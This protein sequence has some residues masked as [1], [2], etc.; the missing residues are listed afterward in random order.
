[1]KIFRF[2]RQF[3]ALLLC[4]TMILGLMPGTA[5]A[6]E[7]TT[8]DEGLSLSG[9]SGSSEVI[10]LRE[11]NI[12][13]FDMGNGTF[14]AI[15][16]S[17][18]VH[19]L[20]SDG[21]W[22]D[23]DFGMTLT[24][25]RS[26][27]VYAN[28]EAGAAF[29][30]NYVANQPIM[31]L[32]D[33]ENAISMSLISTNVNS[34]ARLNTNT[35][36]AAEVT[37]PQNSFQ[38]I[39]DAKSAD[40]S[41]KILYEEVLPGVDLEYIVDPGT[42]K[43]NIIVNEKATAYQYSFAL[44]L[45]GL[46]PVM[47][48]DGSIIVYDQDADTKEYEIPA[49]FMYDALGNVSE[50]VA[51]ALIGSGNT[52]TLTV[53]A[54]ADWINTEGRSFPVTIDP[55][56]VISTE[57]TYDT[58]IDSDN[59]DTARGSN[60]MLWVRSNRISYIKVPTPSIPSY[61][62]VDWA[63][64]TAFYY[65]F[66]YVTSGA[67]NVSAHRVTGGSWNEDTLT[68]NSIANVSNY[69]LST[70]TL[71]TVTA[72]AGSATASNPAQANFFITSTFKNWVNGTTSNYGI[73]LRYAT[74]STNLSVV[75]KSSE[76]SYTYRPRITYQYSYEEE[77]LVSALVEYGFASSSEVVS[78]SD[79]F[80]LLLR[81][82]SS[83]FS[84]AGISSLAEDSSGSSTRSC[85]NYYDD[86]FVFS[87]DTSSG[88][89]NG[90]VKMR[91]Q[92]SDSYD[93]NDPGVTVS[94]VSLSRNVVIGHLLSPTTAESYELLCALDKV[95]GPGS[96]E[97]DGVLANYFKSARADA[98]YLIA[99]EYV[100]LIAK[101]CTSG[102]VLQAPDN[103]TAILTEIEEINELLENPWLD[104]ETR[105]VYINQL[106][107]LSRVPDAIEQNNSNAGYNVYNN[108]NNTILIGNAYNL[109]SY[110]K[111]AILATHTG[112]VTF[113]SFAAEVQF[114]ADALDDYLSSL[115]AY[116]EAA[117]RADM[118]IGEE[119]ESGMFDDYY[120][121]DSSIVQTQIQYHGEY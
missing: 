59:P 76:A 25:T 13:H 95:T 36:I 40:F 77:S 52:Y 53:T 87:V 84:A 99:E 105:L 65:Y 46:Y 11:E 5:N 23:I 1:M 118:A 48:D 92:E 88:V 38:T 109:T 82:L 4:M 31:T 63:A 2:K 49:P 66:D 30:E 114:H 41:S 72:A 22:Q 79:G 45:T 14:Q 103:Y 37:N 42:V 7:L 9:D 34:A 116:Y 80:S 98:P 97:Y 15:A 62:E 29:A 101:K 106:S 61:A 108:S 35:T 100:E 71:D 12:K 111:Y 55:S 21:N 81:P 70:A 24:G 33:E 74:G 102:G 73:G 104:N 67:V 60:S 54:N 56:Y 89:A 83:V 68:W 119:Y 113:N 78:T 120:D 58:Y 50:D 85:A 96:Y 18:P 44:N 27:R 6:L 93:G 57:T 51:Y 20:D 117:L 91:E 43:E 69:G 115:P 16:Y 19:K 107:D 3:I 28:E 86:W 94:F 64:L 47:Q 10:A 75:F 112:N 8:T 121:L 17:H 110:E 32:S 26:N 90:L 39:E